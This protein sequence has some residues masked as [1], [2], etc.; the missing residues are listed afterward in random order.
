MVLAIVSWALLI[1]GI[2][3]LIVRRK[4]R[5]RE[6]LEYIGIVC[7]ALGT[8]FASVLTCMAFTGNVGFK[9]DGAYSEA[10]PMRQ[11]QTWAGK[12]VLVVGDSVSDLGMHSH[13]WQETFASALG[14]TVTTHAKGGATLLAM[15]DGNP[16]DGLEALTQ[17]EVSGKDLIILFGGANDVN[18]GV[19][20]GQIGDTETGTVC[21]NYYY[22][23]KRIY[24]LLADADNITCPV[25]LVGYYNSGTELEETQGP[26]QT[27]M[28]VAKWLGLPCADLRNSGINPATWSIY[29]R[30]DN[31]HLTTA[32]NILIGNQIA[33][34]VENTVSPGLSR[35]ILAVYRSDAT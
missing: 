13:P 27:I 3:L 1:V 33:K 17:E 14:C 22:A 19:P 24:A 30:E 28:D 12:N 21:G 7:T 6:E 10:A 15:I 11:N 5:H 31:K 29:G 20:L 18:W 8:V 32:G 2:I 4:T 26:R 23:V 16:G 35:E 34:F 25:M 9:N